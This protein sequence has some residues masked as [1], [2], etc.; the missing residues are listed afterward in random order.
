[1]RSNGEIHKMSCLRIIILC[2]LALVLLRLADGA[3]PTTNLPSAPVKIELK[4][5]LGYELSNLS[6]T[7]VQPQLACVR[8]QDRDI[9]LLHVFRVV[10]DPM[11]PGESRMLFSPHGTRE[12]NMCGRLKSD[13]VVIAAFFEDGAVWVSTRKLVTT[14]VGAVKEN[15]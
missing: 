8:T 4:G 1:V 10:E 9:E 7:S 15:Q 13:L 3:P 12:T 6:T 5:E 14:A 11:P 2:S